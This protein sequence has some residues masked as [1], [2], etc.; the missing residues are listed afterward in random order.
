MYQSSYKAGI[1]AED[2]R[3]YIFQEREGK[4]IKLNFDNSK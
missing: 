4:V 1:G 2:A 3:K